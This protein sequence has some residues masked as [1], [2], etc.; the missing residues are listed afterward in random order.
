MKNAGRNIL[1]F[2]DLIHVELFIL[3][4]NMTSKI[5]PMDARII[6]AF[7]RHYHR[8]LAQNVLD[9]NERSKENI[10]NVD[11]LT[12][13][14]WSIAAWNDISKE[15]I[16]SCFNHT[17]LFVVDEIETLDGQLD[18]TNIDREIEEIL[19]QFL[20]YSSNDVEFFLN[21]MPEDHICVHQDYTDAKL[22]AKNA[23]VLPSEKQEEEED[24]EETMIE[25]L[26]QEKLSSIQQ[27][28]GILD[29][30]D[31]L[32]VNIHSGLQCIQWDLHM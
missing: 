27:T 9:R 20:G 19:L 7:K 22:L 6:A 26:L 4:P 12:T 8:L 10:Y 30:K 31:P 1:L 17:R 11:Q 24:D 15:S 2:M 16:Q 28:I 21:S 25:F 5:Q 18:E 29:V 3:P 23:E 14:R 13:M 32:Q